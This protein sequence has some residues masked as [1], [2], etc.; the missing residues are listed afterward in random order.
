MPTTAATPYDYFHINAVS[1][2]EDGN[3]LVDARNTW[4]VYNVDRRTG[5][6]NWRLGGKNSDFTLGAGR[7]V[8]LAAQPEAGRADTIRL[9]DNEAAPAVLPHSRVIWIRRD[10]RNHT[11]TLIR[12]VRAP[13][14]PARP[15]AGQLAGA[16]RRQHVRRL[17][18]RPG[19][20]SEFDADRRPAL[21]R[22]RARRATT[23]TAP[24]AHDWHGKPDADP[25]VTASRNADGTVD[26][27]RDLER[28]HR[29]GALD[30][31]RRPARPTTCAASAT[32]S[33]N[34]LDTAITLTTG[35]SHIAVVAEDEDGH[36]IDQ[37]AVVP[38]A[39]N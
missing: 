2:D 18:R 14:R 36:R 30:R 13:G 22:Q 10:Q 28:R 32:A 25:T 21:R 9:F 5:H 8:R 33:W 7:R 12:V 11:A 3:L 39:P 24:T 23:P 38:I 37:S 6:V 19:A 26:R 27:P 15:V 4:T 17:G 1:L 16:R 35:A 20:F 29:G 34:G 31:P